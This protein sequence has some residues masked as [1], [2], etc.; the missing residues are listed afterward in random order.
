MCLALICGLRDFCMIFVN[1]IIIKEGNLPMSR[2]S[3]NNHFKHLGLDQ[4]RLDYLRLYGVL[5]PVGT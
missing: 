5:V 2:V 1:I 4:Q 3:K